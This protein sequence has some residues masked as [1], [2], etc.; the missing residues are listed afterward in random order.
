[1]YRVCEAPLTGSSRF[2]AALLNEV[3]GCVKQQTE[4]FNS[5]DAIVT[6]AGPRNLAT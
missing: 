5:I 1:M 2:L 3:I 4:H 6:V